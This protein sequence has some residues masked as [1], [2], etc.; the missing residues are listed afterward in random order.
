M[1]VF[2]PSAFTAGMTLSL[3]LIIAIGPQNAHLL[4]VGLQRKH[5]WLTVV[6]CA[7]ADI[8]LIAIGVM[9][10]GSLGDLSKGI[11][12]TLLAAAA[13]V[14]VIYGW[15]AAKR[16]WL[17]REVN[18]LGAQPAETQTMSRQQAISNALA[19]SWLNPHA[20]IDT[21][22]LIGGASLAYQAQARTSFGLGAVV[23]SVVWFIAL[24]AIAYWLGKRA[25]QAAWLHWIDALVAVMMWSI[26]ATILNGLM[27]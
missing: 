1:S 13:T 16:F 4:R 5:L 2:V 27:N 14:L 12:Q 24:G 9:G 25:S 22:V 18:L 17:A 20:W 21:A 19:F 8:T 11:Y 23:G 15:Q 10:L 6:V 26:A 7:L 3:S